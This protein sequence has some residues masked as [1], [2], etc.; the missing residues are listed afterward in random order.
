M[1]TTIGTAYVQIEPSAKGIAQKTQK[2][3]GGEMDLAGSTSG[4]RLGGALAS[5]MTKYIS[6]AAIGSAITKSLTE[7]AKL[8]QSLGGVETLFKNSASTVIKNANKAWKTAGISANEYMEQSTSYAAS[9]LQSLGG[10]T[11]K[12]AKY[13]DMA[14]TDMSDNAAKFGSDL[15]SIQNAYSGFAKQNYTM[16]DNL[17]LGYGG[18]K[19]EMERLLQDATKL[20]GVEYNIDSLSDVYDAIHVIQTELDVTGTTAKEGAAT[21]SGSFAAM[22]ASATN[23][24]GS[25]TIGKNVG[26]SM[27]AFVKSIGTFVGKNLIPALGRI[28]ASIPELF[29][30]I[31]WVKVSQTLLKEVSKFVNI[32]LKWAEGLAQGIAKGMPKFIKELPKFIS[33]IADIVNNN[34]PKILATGVKI[35]ITLAKG[36]VQAIPTFVKSIPQLTKAAAKAFTAF[37]WGSLG[38][39]AITLL[40]SGV[41]KAAG[42]IGSALSAK[43]SNIKGVFTSAFT[44][45]KESAIKLVNGMIDKIKGLFPFSIKKLLSVAKLPT[46]ALTTGKKFFDGLGKV[47]YP[48]GITQHAEGGIFTQPTVLGGHMFGEAGNEGIIPLDPFWEKMDAI[49]QAV[50][51]GGSTAGTVVINLDGETIA[52]STVNYINGQ[53]QRYGTSPINI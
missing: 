51:G 53:V 37:G 9:L 38:K 33:N 52:K 4:T 27:Q 49:L 23:L 20:S 6:A 19:T 45:A 29:T 34:A 28:V 39:S 17:K 44:R 25:L 31:N 14:I 2:V 46:F 12:A 8:E 40:K 36:L 22:K 3:L 30:S 35:V 13:A 10:D 48:T 1:S 47:N 42:G 16:L 7:G 41:T 5:S 32:A 21:L 11:A 26:K 43:L 15:G 24:L 50:N 18:T